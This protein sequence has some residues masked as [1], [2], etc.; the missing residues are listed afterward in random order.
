MKEEIFSISITNLKEAVKKRDNRIYPNDAL[1]YCSPSVGGWGVVR[2]ACLVP[3]SIV[4]FVIP[5][6]CGRHGAIASMMHNYN[7]QLFYMYLSQVDI[8]TGEHMDKIDRAVDEILQKLKRKPKALVLCSTC[9]DDLLGS[10]YEGKARI[11]EEKFDI[12]VRIGRMNPIRKE[13]KRPP[14][15]M[16]QRTI[17]DY[18][19]NSSEK[20]NTINIIGSFAN[21]MSGCE[22]HTILRRS[23]I[24]KVLHIRDFKTYE[25]YQDMSKSKYSLVVKPGGMVAA[26]EMKKRFKI[27]F[28]SVPVSFRL[29]GIEENYRKIEKILGKS[30]E[31]KKYRENAEEVIQEKVKSLGRISVAV[32]GTANACPFELARDLVE[33]GF[34]VPYVFADKLLSSDKIH[35]QWLK[36]N[37]PYIKV[38]STI[39]PSMISFLEKKEKVDLAVGFDAGYFC[40]KSKT[41]PLSLDEQLYGYEGA[42]TLYER[43]VEVFENPQDLK[44]E[45]YQS[46]MVI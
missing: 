29:E 39:S 25:E 24:E 36:E 16:I 26:K 8:V 13:S 37:A 45:M 22:I 23:G 14:E 20:R 17:Y 21:I 6:G 4:L 32:G 35:V 27:P 31:Y 15:V 9:T 30:L 46:G 28:V 1:H 42:K 41:V 12:D 33:R 11:L 34:Y 38:Y 19:R 40:S 3:E 18:L 7:K 43:M 44:K 2:V 5:M 10:D